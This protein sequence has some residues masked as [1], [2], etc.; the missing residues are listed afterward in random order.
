MAIPAGRRLFL[1]PPRETA[2]LP[3]TPALSTVAELVLFAAA[4]GTGLVAARALFHLNGPLDHVLGLHSV[5][6]L[7]LVLGEVAGL[8]FG[9]A[10]LAQCRRPLHRVF[11]GR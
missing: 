1:R 9:L 8:G 6:C 3:R 2:P 11:G 10:C 7:G 5:Q 4:A